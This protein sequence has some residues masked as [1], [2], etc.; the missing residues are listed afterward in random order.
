MKSKHTCVD[1]LDLQTFYF[2]LSHE[3]F[4]KGVK[5][6]MISAQTLFFFPLFCGSRFIRRI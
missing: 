4:E 1:E 5:F 3:A 2:F 6:G